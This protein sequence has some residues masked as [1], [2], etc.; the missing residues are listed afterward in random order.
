MSQYDSSKS[1]FGHFINHRRESA[2]ID[3]AQ[4]R[5]NIAVN[6]FWKKLNFV[7]ESFFIL[8]QIIRPSN[9]T[10]KRPTLEL[11]GRDEPPKPSNFSIKAKLIRAP[12]E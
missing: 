4:L 1:H 8:T 10:T 9:P 5:G 6:S 3:S 11:T 7:A 12:V 2:S